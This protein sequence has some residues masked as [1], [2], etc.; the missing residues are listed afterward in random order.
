[1]KNRLFASE[2]YSLQVGS[3]NVSVVIQFD[4]RLE[5]IDFS[6]DCDSRFVLPIKEVNKIES[7]IIKNLDDWTQE[8]KEKIHNL[9]VQRKQLIYSLS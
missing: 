7:E 1:M 3:I 2:S 4:S 9:N 5:V 8:A 6:W